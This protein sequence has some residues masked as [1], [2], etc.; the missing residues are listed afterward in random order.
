MVPI[1]SWINLE[2]QGKLYKFPAFWGFK[3]MSTGM[4]DKHANPCATM[5]PGTKS[6]FS[7][8]PKMP[9]SNFM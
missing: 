3:N 2:A 4:A 6:A 8:R 1:L 5:A 7:G 9:P